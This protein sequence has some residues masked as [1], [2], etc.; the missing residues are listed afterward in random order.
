VEI[1]EIRGVDIFRREEIMQED[2]LIG[3]RFGRLV[4][5]YISGKSKNGHKLCFCQCDCGNTKEVVDGNLK[6]G[7]ST[8]CGCY[9]KELF[10]K[11]QKEYNKYDLS[12]QY[13]V[14]YTKKGE[15]F[16]FDLEDYDLI[17]DYCWSFVKKGYVS[18]TIKIN[19]KSKQILLHR[20]LMNFPKEVDHIDRNKANNKKNNLRSVTSSQNATN[21]GKSKN[22]KTGII[23]VY[24][25][26][27][28]N[29][30]HSNIYANGERLNLGYYKDFAEAVIVRLKAEL[31][32]FG[33]DFAPQR[34]LFEQYGII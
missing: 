26:K 2:S 6:S 18:T 1:V 17:K 30:Y 28:S 9:Q 14:G 22:N 4:V 19:N 23:G 13:G 34:H 8:S 31:E 33:L 10:S 21:R 3:K 5:L 24:W 32:Y 12:G 7:H 16:Y 25:R 11:A 27:Q 29:R 15:E 20:L